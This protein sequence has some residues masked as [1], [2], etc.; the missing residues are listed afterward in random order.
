MSNLSTNP[1]YIDSAGVTVR[2]SPVVIKSIL[3]M[4]DDAV[5]RNIAPSDKLEIRDAEGG[6]LIFSKV[7][8]ADGDGVEIGFG[9]PL[10]V[11]GLYISRLDG[12][13]LYIQL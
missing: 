6:N 12:G 11:K 9:E 1:V 5:G 2:T 10:H 7:A 4:N 13:V 3:W 8:V